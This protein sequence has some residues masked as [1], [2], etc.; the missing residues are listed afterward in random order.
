M[1]TYNHEK[2]EK[3][4]SKLGADDLYAAF[5]KIKEYVNSRLVSEQAIV[6]SLANDLQQRIDRLNNA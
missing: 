5:L 6:E 1:A 2:I 3:E 4:L